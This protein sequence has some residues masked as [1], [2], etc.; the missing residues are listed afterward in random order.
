[1]PSY[2]YLTD[3]ADFGL[4]L[5][6]LGLADVPVYIHV[7]YLT[8]KAALAELQLPLHQLWRMG[9]KVLEAGASTVW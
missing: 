1:M 7:D 8:V 9:I 5:L 3:Q 6:E 2:C 4:L